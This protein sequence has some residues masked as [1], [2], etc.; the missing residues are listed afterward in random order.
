MSAS[1]LNNKRNPTGFSVGHLTLSGSRFVILSLV[2]LLTALTIGAFSFV[3]QPG[4]SLTKILISS[5]SITILALL[6]WAWFVRTG[7][8]N[9]RIQ[10]ICLMAFVAGQVARLY[11]PFF[12]G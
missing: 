1:S 12:A 4:D 7:V 8:K 9:S 5:Q 11:S 10:F 2:T 3:A 6:V